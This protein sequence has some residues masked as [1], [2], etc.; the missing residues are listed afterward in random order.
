MNT[1]VSC[2][3]WGWCE[4]EVQLYSEAKFSL[5]LAV[6]KQLRAGVLN[7]G[8]GGYGCP[9]SVYRYLFGGR[10][11]FVHF[12]LSE[13]KIGCVEMWEP[14]FR[15]W[16]SL[17]DQQLGCSSPWILPCPVLHL[18]QVM[19]PMK[20]KHLPAQNTEEKIIR[21]LSLGVLG[22]QTIAVVVSQPDIYWCLG[23]IISLSPLLPVCAFI[24][25]VRWLQL[26]GLGTLLMSLK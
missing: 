22:E 3:L 16:K 21:A 20:V 9:G 23:R 12:C 17:C 25:T 15:Y 4:F 13:L 2:L 14:D 5:E 6:R 11:G 26:R 19:W 7:R 18:I 10:A 1:N 24:S 8:G